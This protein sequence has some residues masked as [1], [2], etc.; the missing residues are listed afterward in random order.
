MRESLDQLL[1]A[2]KR[3]K[4]DG[5]SSVFLEPTTLAE[6][7]ATLSRLPKAESSKPAPAS[8][9]IAQNPPAAKA[10][11]GTP[12]P[13]VLE[14]PV[15]AKAPEPRL[16]QTTKTV[17]TKPSTHNS[18]G[19]APDLQ[20]PLGDKNARWNWLR[21]Q[22]LNCPVCKR[23]IKP[24]KQIVFGSGNLNAGIF[25]C[26]E[27]PGPEEE[28]TG[29][30]FVGQAGQLLDRI[31]LAMGLKREQVYLANVLN[32]RPET[33]GGEG[34]RPPSASEMEFCMPYLRAQ[35]DI[36]KPKLI[37]ALGGSAV[38]ALLGESR[39]FSVTRNRGEWH[40]FQ[41]IPTL[42]TF[43]PTYVLKMDKAEIKRLIWVDMLAVMERLALPISEK[44]RGYFSKA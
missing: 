12:T 36:V 3:L 4:Q 26:G 8:A 42:I 37:V 34:N 13:P 20:L 18:L 31:I 5:V 40:E 7:D 22:V 38:Q 14:K 28:N 15:Q 21:E 16:P 25:F 19:P 2:L 10:S 6:L 11:G 24:G 41:G 43:H 23:Q 1:D 33:E 17:E 9:R 29:Q 44:Q 32:W 39:K 27:A 35:I 30:P